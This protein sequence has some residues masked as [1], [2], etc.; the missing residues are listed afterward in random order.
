[1]R[2]S[3][4]STPVS[5]LQNLLRGAPP[6]SARSRSLVRRTRGSGGKALTSRALYSDTSAR[7]LPRRS[8]RRPGHPRRPATTITT[9]P[10]FSASP[11]RTRRTFNAS[12]G[13]S[14]RHRPP[15]L[16]KHL[17]GHYAAQA[18]HHA[19]IESVQER[20]KYTG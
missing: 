18:R 3:Y 17:L 11:R 4:F 2:A 14:N 10:Q 16:G 6:R 1:M 8:R 7:T 19:T 5:H 20:N 9:R 13:N 15:Y 12:H